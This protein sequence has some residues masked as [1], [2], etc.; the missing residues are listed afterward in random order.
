VIL[1]L[2]LYYET[3]KNEDIRR[4]IATTLFNIVDS[5][6]QAVQDGGAGKVNCEL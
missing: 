4:D 6:A 5:V 1:S 2:F 3:E